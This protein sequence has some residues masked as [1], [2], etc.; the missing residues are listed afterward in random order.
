MCESHN[1]NLQLVDQAQTVAYTNVYYSLVM[2]ASLRHQ[3]Q[4]L[5]CLNVTR[6]PKPLAHI[7]RGNFMTVWLIFQSVTTPC[8]FPDRLYW[9]PKNAL[10]QI[11]EAQIL[12]ENQGLRRIA[13]ELLKSKIHETGTNLHIDN[14]KRDRTTLT[15]H[16]IDICPS[17][18]SDDMSSTTEM[19]TA[20]GFLFRMIISVGPTG[21]CLKCRSRQLPLVLTHH[22]LQ[23]SSFLWSLLITM[24]I[25]CN[26]F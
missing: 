19:G 2:A 6:M 10:K 25:Q 7:L 17:T 21:D 5:R 23:C 1:P 9:F 20:T 3:S 22:P 15:S 26:H 8:E 18:L 14:F 16:P 24:I 12:Q 4:Y 13:K 11:V